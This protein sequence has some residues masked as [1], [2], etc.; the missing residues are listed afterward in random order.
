MF[1][2]DNHSNGEGV[3]RYRDLKGKDGLLQA[4][5]TTEEVKIIIMNC[6][7]GLILKISP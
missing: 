5:K 3:K 1:D 2:E 7:R 4:L 6:R